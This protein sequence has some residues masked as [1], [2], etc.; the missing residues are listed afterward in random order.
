MDD[1]VWGTGGGGRFFIS[2]VPDGDPVTGVAFFFEV[3][4]VIFFS[5]AKHGGLGSGVEYL[6]FFWEA[7]IETLWQIV[8]IDSHGIF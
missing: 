3:G 8:R 6:L 5:L 2:I 7:M 1:K 4:L